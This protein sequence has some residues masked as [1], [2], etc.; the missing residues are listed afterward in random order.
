MIARW[1]FKLT[2]VLLAAV[3]VAASVDAFPADDDKK[4]LPDHEPAEPVKLSTDFTGL[5]AAASIR[6]SKNNLLM[7]AIAL[8]R[9][10]A[11]NS[12][13]L[14]GEI[15]GKDG[16]PLLSWRV[17][18]LPYYEQMDLFK[19]F[20]LDEPWDSKNNLRLLEKMPKMFVSPRVTV[21][22]KGYTVYQIFSGP[23]A[24]FDKGKTKYNIGNIPDGTANT[25]FAVE[26][27]K[28]VPWTKPADLPFDKE[29]NLSLDFGKAYG[30]KPVG[31]MMDGNAR[32]LDLKK[33]KPETLK[34]AI[35]PDDGQVLGADWDE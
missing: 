6:N 35:L 26:T 24:L 3:F 20:K 5:R 21:K 25:L 12:A 22:R 28:A 23:G 13:S 31:S 33:I 16:K 30:N 10:A 29:K 27:S 18:L 17:N 9:Y 8:H 7:M 19:E 1:P 32:V 2:V 15:L 4:T 14:P 34:N 11:A